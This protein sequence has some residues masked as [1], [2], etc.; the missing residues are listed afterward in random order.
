MEIYNPTK[1]TRRSHPTSFQ[2]TWIFPVQPIIGLLHQRWL[3]SFILLL[4]GIQNIDI[5]TKLVKSIIVCE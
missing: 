5:E 4:I 2:P 1:P 3:L